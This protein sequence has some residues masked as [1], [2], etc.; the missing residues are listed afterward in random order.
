M[1]PEIDSFGDGKSAF[2]EFDSEAAP[3]APPVP[4]PPPQASRPYP[5]DR[6]ESAASP[7]FVAL[8]QRTAQAVQSESEVSQKPDDDEFL[9]LRV[10]IVNNVT[11]AST[12]TPYVSP[13]GLPKAIDDDEPKPLLRIQ[14]AA[15]LAPLPPVLPVLPVL[16]VMARP[17]VAPAISPVISPA[18]L[19]RTKMPSR[20]VA[21][22]AGAI[23]LSV[24]VGIVV[25][26][27]AFNRESESAQASLPHALRPRGFGAQRAIK[28]LASSVSEPPAPPG[29]LV[30]RRGTG[31]LGLAPPAGVLQSDSSRAS[32]PNNDF[33]Q[34]RGVP[35]PAGVVAEVRRSAEGLTLDIIDSAF[36]SP[37][38]DATNRDVAPPRI[39]FPLLSAPL[40][41]GFITADG[42]IIEVIVN[43]RG[44]VDGVRTSSRPATVGESNRLLN[45]LSAA[46]N[47]RFRPAVRDGRPVRYRVLVPLS[48][49]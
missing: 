23:V 4:P 2:D 39:V 22:A 32:V 11:E 49:F 31:P 7:G 5:S 1:P 47:W 38:Y 28:F 27:R 37:A 44:T 43:E 45:A 20:S 15:D 16:P 34:P 13:P 17:I 24:T 21:I 41:T 48:A 12:S 36:D 46:K 14:R 29:R 30:Q 35:Q 9:A 33:V 8:A 19:E 18:R 42:P 25:Q 6:D 10:R 40:S 3:A 26:V